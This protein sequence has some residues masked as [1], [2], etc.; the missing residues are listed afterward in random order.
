MN[1]GDLLAHCQALN[2]EIVLKDYFLLK[3]DGFCN[4]NRKAYPEQQRVFR[5]SALWQW[6]QLSIISTSQL[7][8]WIFQ[9]WLL[10]TPFVMSLWKTHTSLLGDSGC[11]SCVQENLHMV[12]VLHLFGLQQTFVNS[13]DCYVIFLICFPKPFGFATLHLPCR[14]SKWE[15]RSCSGSVWM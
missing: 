13:F 15:D 11:V 9:R 2:N 6:P 3:D 4:S 14:K 5:S 12:S 10:I 1:K 7:Q 8:S